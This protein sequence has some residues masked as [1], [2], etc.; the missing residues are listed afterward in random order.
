MTVKDQIGGTGTEI[1]AGPVLNERARPDQRGV[2]SRPL[3]A[4]QARQGVISGRV[5]TVLAVS[6]AL[7]LTGILLAF[8]MT[9]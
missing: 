1:E 7:A 3:S 8:V 4:I 6:L 5:V 9:S 2:A